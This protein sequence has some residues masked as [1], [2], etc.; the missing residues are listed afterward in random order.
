MTDTPAQPSVANVLNR[1]LRMVSCSLSM[2]LESA[3]PWSTADHRA[4]RTALARLAADQRLFAG[5][6]AAAIIAYGGQPEA[7][8][9]P[10][11]FAA[12]NDVSLDYL[13]DKI[14]DGLRADVAFAEHCAVEL[15][16]VSGAREVVAELLGNLQ[17]HLELIEEVVGETTAQK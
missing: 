11:E 12:L 17:G 7:G 13:L 5:R 8:A 2:Y 16:D 15:A 6:I 10:T 4:A 9:F 3:K 1:L 14:V